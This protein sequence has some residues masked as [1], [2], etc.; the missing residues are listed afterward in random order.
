MSIQIQF[1]PLKSRLESIPVHPSLEF[2]F[3]G[4]LSVHYFEQRQSMISKFILRTASCNHL[5]QFSTKVG[6]VLIASE[7]DATS[8]ISALDTTD[9]ALKGSKWL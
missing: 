7:R 3:D 5:M 2:E 1:H 4:K 8:K 6:S 9:K